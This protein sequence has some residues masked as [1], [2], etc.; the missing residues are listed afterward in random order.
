MTRTPSS[1]NWKIFSRRWQET[2]PLLP[3]WLHLIK[4]D[5]DGRVATDDMHAK[6]KARRIPLGRR[7]ALL[8][9]SGCYKGTTLSQSVYTFVWSRANPKPEKGFRYYR[10]QSKSAS[11]ASPKKSNVFL[12]IP[13]AGFAHHYYLSGCCLSTSLPTPRTQPRFTDGYWGWPLP[14][15]LSCHYAQA[16]DGTQ[17]TAQPSRGATEKIGCPNAGNKGQTAS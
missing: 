4:L 17:T 5:A 10:G 2:K 16:K 12:P 14:A 15:S 8:S 7:T 9:R 6:L 3:Q 13:V 11:L 1:R